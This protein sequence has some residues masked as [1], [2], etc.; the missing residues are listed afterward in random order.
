MMRSP[1][2]AS[3]GT[4]VPSVSALTHRLKGVVEG[5]F[6]NVQVE[7]ELSN[8]KV[9]ARGHVWF[10]LRDSEAEL[11]AVMWGSTARRIG[12][13]LRDGKKMVASGD[14][15]I[16]APHGR[17]RLIVRSIRDAGLG[18]RLVQLQALRNRLSAEGL[19]EPSRKR[20]LPLL[21][22]RVGVVTSETGDALRDILTT[23]DRRFPTRVLVAPCRVQGE[24][25][26]DEIVQSIARLD[27]HP[28]VDV[29]IVGRGGGSIEDL[30][31][32]NEERVA[33][34]IAQARTPIVSAVGHEPD[35]LLS[36][37]VADRR[38]ATP[39]A[40]AELVV[41]SRND[42]LTSLDA[43]TQSMARV[44]ER[45]L[46]A[47]RARLSEG[48]QQIQRSVHERL[49]RERGRTAELGARLRN[50]HPR[51]RLASERTGLH[52]LERRLVMAQ[53]AGALAR[54]NEL[55]RVRRALEVLSPV[56]C[57]ERG[58]AIVRG[59][60]G[61]VLSEAQDLS[62]GDSV[63]ILLHR[64]SVEATIDKVEGPHEFEGRGS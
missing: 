4:Q 34:A 45:R 42:L 63:N 26:A 2:P 22:R 19:F 37:D 7:G 43:W 3:E 21:P 31:P 35:H 1:K 53:R 6:A 52:G 18:D 50:L 61:R 38:A 51:Q 64:G 25:A 16:Y 46:D 62:A 36:D 13:E 30:W 47:E 32:F 41:P 44:L 23:L 49:R 56:A 54:R 17:Y 20:D 27:A 12:P 15:E 14:I 58:Y 9:S 55:D 59:Q 11:S 24:H 29:I 33:R 8:V 60:G 5:A 28:E 40:A 48:C 39:T 10:T 57:L